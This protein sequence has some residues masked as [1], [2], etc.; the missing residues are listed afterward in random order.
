MGGK[1]DH[2]MI[3]VNRF[4]DARRFYSWLM[5]ALGYPNSMSF[6]AEGP[7]RGIGW[8]GDSGSVWVQEAAPVYRADSFH[9]HRIGLCEI[10]FGAD[11]REQVNAL[12][13]EIEKHGGKITDAPREYDYVPGYYAVF[14]TDPDGLKLE[15]VHIPR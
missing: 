1:I 11:N 5:P 10:A 15:A 4:D 14:F 13:R 8:W 7:K 9:R 2:L 3:N 12:A 6:P